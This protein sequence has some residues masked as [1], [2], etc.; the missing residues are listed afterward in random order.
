MSAVFIVEP[1]PR[2]APPAE[3]FADFLRRHRLVVGVVRRDGVYHASLPTGWRVSA[4]SYEYGEPATEFAQAGAL[5][6]VQRLAQRLAGRYIKG[7]SVIKVPPLLVPSSMAPG[8]WVTR[9]GA[10]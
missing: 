1:E 9:D 3:N 5:Q 10:A 2:R 6:A 4:N 7:L 8:D